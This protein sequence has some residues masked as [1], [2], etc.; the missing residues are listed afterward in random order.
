MF[1]LHNPV[2]WIDPTG[3]FAQESFILWDPDQHWYSVQWHVDS[4]ASALEELFGG[5]VHQIDTRGW[6]AEDFEAWWNN[7]SG[8]I[9]AV[10]FFGH[11]SW[12][13]IIFDYAQDQGRRGVNG[14][15]METDF[16][17]TQHQ[18]NNVLNLT[19]Q[20]IAMLVLMSCNPGAGTLNIADNFTRFINGGTVFAPTG[21]LY[22]YSRLWFGGGFRSDSGS[23]ATLTQLPSGMVM[24][25]ELSLSRRRSPAHFI[26]E[27]YGVRFQPTNQFVVDGML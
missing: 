25:G 5:T 15:T 1:A 16:G 20:N 8:D 11:G 3:L 4:M 17:L 9:G 26:R 13:R 23:I 18:M 7:L 19:N 10:V 12:D 2:R 14:R 24:I 21:Y 22:V 27:M 6:R